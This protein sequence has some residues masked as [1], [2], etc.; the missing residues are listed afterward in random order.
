MAKAK[1]KPANKDVNMN[2]RVRAEQLDKW[3]K[4]AERDARSLSSWVAVT[5]DRAI[6]KERN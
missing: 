5:L 6:E 3:K 1:T 2:I 4:A